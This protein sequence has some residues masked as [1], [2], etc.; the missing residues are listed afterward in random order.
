MVSLPLAVLVVLGLMAGVS[1]WLAHRLGV[2][3]SQVELARLQ[4]SHDALQT[5]WAQ[6]E[7][8]DSTLTPLRVAMSELAEQVHSAERARVSALS[9]LS[10]QMLAVGRQVDSATQGVTEQAQMISRALAGTQSQGTWGEMQLRRLVESAGML[11]HVHFDQQVTIRSDDTTVRPDMVIDIGSG[12]TV[13]VDAKVSLDA[14]LTPDATDEQ[15]AA[16]HA[17]AVGEHVTR[18][19]GKNY[20]K[21]A[22]TPE[23]VILFLPSEHML[24]VALRE[25]PALLQSAFDK[26]V[27]LATPTTLMATLRSVSW[28]W[29]QA[30]MADQAREVLE[31]GQLLY[32]RLT[33][34]TGH[35]TKTGKSLNDAVDA[36]NSMLAS[37]DAR[38][39]PA[40]RRLGQL[41]VPEGEEPQVRSI[42][43]RARTAETAEHALDTG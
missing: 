5:Q 41:S 33:T 23:F 3:S 38:V 16:A 10:E 6:R 1:V 40:A 26:K 13:V 21:A 7:Q 2:R 39:L 15:R 28:A 14:F 20:W 8:L 24:S 12:R 31:A 29:Q 22:G 43:V 35:L 4:G 27:V 11:E 9:G 42:D 17:A 37:L 32:R 19:S 18:L 30:D 25:R 36:Y 34:M